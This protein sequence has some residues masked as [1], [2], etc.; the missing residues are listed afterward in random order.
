MKL[1][2]D[3][4]SEQA[5]RSV[6]AA[7]AK[8]DDAGA[9]A[10]KEP[11]V[12]THPARRCSEC[13]ESYHEEWSS[14]AHARSGTSRAYARLHAEVG[15][16]GCDS[17]HRPLV[18][19]LGSEDARAREGVSCDVCHGITQVKPERP[20]AKWSLDLSTGVRYGPLCDAKD[21]YFHR[22]GCSPLHEKSEVCAACHSLTWTAP[23]GAV[24][25]VLSEYEEWKASAFAAQDMSCQ[26][27]HMPSRE[28]EVAK[29]AGT[30]EGVSSHAFLSDALDLRRDA[31]VLQ[32]QAK[33]SDE[34]RVQVSLR[35]TN[36]AGHALPSGFPG[37]QVVIEARALNSAGEAMD[38]AE[39]V[40][41]RTLADDSA[42]E[43]PFHRATQVLHDTRI[44]SRETRE[45]ELT[46]SAPS[47]GTLVVEA[48][49][50][51][52]S[53]ALAQQLGD[54]VREQ[55]LLSAEIK[56]G[57]PAKRRRIAPARMVANSK[58]EGLK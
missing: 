55:A 36:R 28:A 53:P 54:E 9:Q 34:D 29:G 50:R 51:K 21:H 25:P 49:W 11:Q 38:R 45:H 32:V 27:C 15:G 44:P 47:Q 52:L 13:H 20:A 8:R 17:C 5:A 26:F 57:P 24:I 43:V 16:E 6:Q 37:R 22:M 2:P 1:E 39:Y 31:L 46:L 48:R 19:V 56:L 23:T 40:L 42:Q 30:R 3:A 4:P 41:A 12:Y 10:A 35:M 58:S 14:S 7:E 18:D 33:A